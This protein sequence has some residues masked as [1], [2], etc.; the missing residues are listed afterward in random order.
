MMIPSATIREPDWD[1]VRQEVTRIL[2]DY[3]RIDTSNPPGDEAAAARFLSGILASEGIPHD[4]YESAPGRANLLARLKGDGGGRPLLLIHHMDVVPGGTAAWTFPP[5]GGRIE[6]DYLWGRGALD[7]K[8]L[9]VIHLMALLLLKRGKLPLRRDILLLAVADE[10]QASTCGAQ[11]MIQNHW[12]EIQC[13]YLW[14]EGG[15]GLRKVMSIAAVF[16]IAVSEKKGLGL[17]LTARGRAGHASTPSRG[18]PIQR[19]VKALHNLQGFTPPMRVNQVTRESFRRLGQ[20]QPF[21]RSWVLGH[22]DHPLARALLGAS[23]ARN[24]SLSAIVRDTLAVTRLEAGYKDNVVPDTAEAFLDC[25]LLP[26]TKPEDFLRSLKRAVGDDSIE[27]QV[28]YKPEDVPASPVDSPLF[29]ALE[30][31]IGRQAPGSAVVPTQFPAAT[32]SRFFRA[33]G[34]AAYGLVP[35]LLTQE[36]L[37]TVHGVDERI[38]VEELV[39]G[40]KIAWE[41]VLELCARGP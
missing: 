32:D 22:A 7:A 23:L 8:G 19:L 33:K 40:V 2:S 41:V 14:D 36:E 16:G 38:S 30:R 39:R 3:L 25:R 12:P 4:V 24:P 27:F 6:G 17:R 1:A 37:A 35:V 34:V 29:H 9:G 20:H 18:S 21:P 10:E 26:D 28:V 13:E 5:F 15:F 11:W 31:A